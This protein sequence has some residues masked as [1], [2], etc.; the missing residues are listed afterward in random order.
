MQ[1][2]TKNKNASPKKQMALFRSP[3]YIVFFLMFMSFI[4]SFFHFASAVTNATPIITI[5]ETALIPVLQITADLE[6]DINCDGKVTT[7]DALL[8]L[9]KNSNLPIAPMTIACNNANTSRHIF[10]DSFNNTFTIEESSIPN[11][12]SD[13]DWWLNSGA[14]FY[15][16]GTYGSTIFGKIDTGNRWYNLYNNGWYNKNQTENG[17]YPQSVFR[18][19]TRGKWN[20]YVQQMYYKIENYHLTNSEYRSESNGLLLFNRYR[21][22]HNLYYTGVRVDGHYVIKKKYRGTYYTMT[23]GRY[24]NGTYD[25]NTNPNLIPLHEWIGIKSIVKTLSNNTVKISVYIDEGKTGN[26]ILLDSVI[27]DANNYGG[28]PITGPAHAGIRTDFMDV[29]FDDYSISETE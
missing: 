8:L 22:A 1:S 16:N 18:L 7:I 17:K 24:Y 6:G 29:H 3:V 21:D 9:R 12:S 20:N 26:W 25:K 28:A 11:E 14:Y 10:N 27:D 5:L 15:S 23:Y 13:Q 19:V 2:P 4:I